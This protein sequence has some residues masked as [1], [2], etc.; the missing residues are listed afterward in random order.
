MINADLVWW[1][2][3]LDRCHW[4]ARWATRPLISDE[5][6]VG[7]TQPVIATPKSGFQAGQLNLQFNGFVFVSFSLEHF[8]GGSGYLHTVNIQ[9]VGSDRPKFKMLFAP[10]G[11]LPQ[12]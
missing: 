9:G 8:I 2:D 6:A 5:Q 4:P 10:V 11:K 7:F 3:Q 1:I 12:R